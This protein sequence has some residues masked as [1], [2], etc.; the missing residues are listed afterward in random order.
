MPLLRFVTQNASIFVL[1]ALLIALTFGCVSTHYGHEYE[2]AGAPLTVSCSKD[3]SISHPTIKSV[4][5]V[6]EN[7]GNSWIEA[8][9]DSFVP[10]PHRGAGDIAVLNPQ[11]IDSFL[12][13]YRFQA[14]KDGHN[15]GLLLAGLVIGS[16]VASGSGNSGV[17]AAALGGAVAVSAAT[18]LRDSFN[19][20]NGAQFQFGDNHVLGPAFEVPPKSF[21]RRSILL[22]TEAESPAFAWPETI[23]LCLA[24]DKDGTGKEC[25]A[26]KFWNPRS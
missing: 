18:G 21:V 12:S 14:A 17:G 3:Y 2:F 24:A 23:D 13:A 1:A 16:A 6:F 26:M 10:H 8:K 4:S 9:V 19:D 20:G 22:Q 7:T 11:R 15:T 5:C 25:K